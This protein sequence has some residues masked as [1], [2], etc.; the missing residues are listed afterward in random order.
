MILREYRSLKVKI[1]NGIQ[2]HPKFF[3]SL[4]FEEYDKEREKRLLDVYLFH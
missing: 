4:Q 2:S 3:V 1:W